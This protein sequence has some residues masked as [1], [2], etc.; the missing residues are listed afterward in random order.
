MLFLTLVL[1][2]AAIGGRVVAAVAAVAASLLVN[3]FFVQP[4][5]TLTIAEPEHIVSLVVF[6]GVAIT[7][8]T[9]VDIAAR[10]AHE[11]QRARIEATALARSAA[12]MAADPC[13]GLQPGLMVRF[14]EL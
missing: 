5:Y 9:L 13:C 4:Y 7:V 12:T 1:I 8:G 11:S 3:W 6:V 14:M 10:R 2:V